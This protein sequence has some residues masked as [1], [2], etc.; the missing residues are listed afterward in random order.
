MATWADVSSGWSAWCPSVWRVVR[1]CERS[2]IRQTSSSVVTA[3]DRSTSSSR[4]IRTSADSGTG[5]VGTNRRVTC[6]HP[7]PAQFATVD[8]AAHRCHPAAPC[9]PYSSSPSCWSFSS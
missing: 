3:G 2:R 6:A 4:T 9:E 1:V 8:S 7:E 5:I